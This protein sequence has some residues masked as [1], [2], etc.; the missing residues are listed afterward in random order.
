MQLG[1]GPPKPPRVAPFGKFFAQFPRLAN[2]YITNAGIGGQLPRQ[3]TLP[4]TLEVLSL[5]G[6]GFEGGWVGGRAGG[7]AW[8]ACWPLQW[9]WARPVGWLSLQGRGQQGCGGQCALTDD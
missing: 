1:G 9:H 4:K 7:W 8:G 2:L 3:G 6:C 5:I